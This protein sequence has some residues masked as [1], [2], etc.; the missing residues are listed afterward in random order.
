MLPTNKQT[1]KNIS[2][3]SSSFVVHRI[4]L[5][6][7]F[8]VAVA[9]GSGSGNDNNKVAKTECIA[10]KE[11]LSSYECLNS[12]KPRIP[13]INADERCQGW[14]EKGECKVKTRENTHTR[15]V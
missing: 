6:I 10:S 1:M 13:C 8:A 5:L 3:A 15:T 2:Y 12:N 11:D 14:A 7:T 4:L 9:F